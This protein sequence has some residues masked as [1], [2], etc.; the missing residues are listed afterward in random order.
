[1]PYAGDPNAKSLPVFMW[2]AKD[3]TM[4]PFEAS[5]RLADRLAKEGIPHVFLECEHGVHTRPFYDPGWFAKAL[6]WL[7]SLQF[8]L[9]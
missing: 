6:D 3:D 1:M 4:V 9:Q 2:H 5:G 7:A 8:V